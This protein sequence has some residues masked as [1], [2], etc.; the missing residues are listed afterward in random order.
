MLNTLDFDDVFVEERPAWAQCVQHRGSQPRS[1][2][3]QFA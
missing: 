3:Q 1:P 2:A